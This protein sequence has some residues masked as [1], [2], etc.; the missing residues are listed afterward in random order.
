MLGYRTLVLPVSSRLMLHQVEHAG[1]FAKRGADPA[2]KLRE[3]VGAGKQLVC[4]L[5]VAL[6]EGVVPFR[7][8]IS[9]RTGPVAERHSAIHTAARLKT[10]V[11]GV[12]GL[13]DLP[14]IMDSIMYRSVPCFLARYSQKSFRISHKI[15]SCR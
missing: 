6:I 1:F 2:G 15:L 12:E 7:R 10:A 13:L 4:Q 9:Q 8:T 3:R 14:E 11:T 5:P